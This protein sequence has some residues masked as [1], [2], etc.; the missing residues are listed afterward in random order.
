[1]HQAAFNKLK[2]AMISWTHLSAIPSRQPYQLYTDASKDCVHATLGQRC[3]HGKYKGHL[4]PIAFMSR[5]MQSA[6]T[7]YPVP[8]G[9]LLAIVLALKQWFHLLRG[10]HHVSFHT[11]HESLR[12]LKTCP[13]PLTSR[14]ARWSQFLEE[15][16][17]T[18]W[19]VPVLKNPAA[20]ACY[21]LTSRQSIHIE[22]AKRRRPFVISF[23]EHWVS[24]EEKPVDEF[25][26]VLK[27]AFSHDE[28][29]AQPY[30]NL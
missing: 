28:V 24:P 13:R 3:E 11:D 22:N 6:E 25:L 17:L 21:C 29:R 20:D 5:K 4:P 10:P 23:V 15:Y 2:Q 8:E 19:Y 27:D 18:L 7:P 30:H 14:R 9:E 26:H 12:D 16:N 1:M